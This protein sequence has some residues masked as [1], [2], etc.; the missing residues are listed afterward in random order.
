[1]LIVK[2]TKG[3]WHGF[4]LTVE[5]LK[6]YS[7]V[8]ESDTNDSMPCERHPDCLVL[9]RD[10]VVDSAFEGNMTALHKKEEDESVPH[11]VHTADTVPLDGNIT[12]MV[13]QDLLLH[14]SIVDLPVPPKAEPIPEN[15]LKVERGKK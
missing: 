13:M 6:R 11:T 7:R 1:M 15:V 5:F 3:K 4:S 8:I 2:D 9:Y 14:D 12:R 10:W